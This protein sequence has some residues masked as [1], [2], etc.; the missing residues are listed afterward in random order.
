[1]IIATSETQTEKE[2][3]FASM[4]V[5]SW[6]WIAEIQWTGIYLT[7]Q[8][9]TSES[10]WHNATMYFGLQ[11]RPFYW[12]WNQDHFYY[13]GDH[14]GMFWGPFSIIWGF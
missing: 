6:R 2:V 14:Y 11:F 10:T 3:A 4:G 8:I 13:D 9:Q 5:R 7:Q 1:M 12:A